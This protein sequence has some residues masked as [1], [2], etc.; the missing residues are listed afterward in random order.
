MAAKIPDYGPW[1]AA[2]DVALDGWFVES[3]DFNH[4]VR[5]IVSGDFATDDDL[6]EY[7]NDIARRLNQ[8]T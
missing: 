7:A 8:E 4:D 5:L 1:R 2:I 3:D 6:R